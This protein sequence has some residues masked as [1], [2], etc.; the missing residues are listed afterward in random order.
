MSDVYV[1]FLSGGP[2]DG[3]KVPNHR[4]WE[5]LV[6]THYCDKHKKGFTE[7][8]VSDAC[9]DCKKHEYVKFEPNEFR[10]AVWPELEVIT[11]D[12]VEKSPVIHRVDMKYVH[13]S[14]DS[15]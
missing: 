4:P 6:I 10:E 3:D 14:T 15:E 7:M 5:N 9:P 11:Q 12:G 1:H 2:Q 8:E 13:S